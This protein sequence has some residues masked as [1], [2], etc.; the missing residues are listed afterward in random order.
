MSFN[1]SKASSRTCCPGNTLSLS[2]VVMVVVGQKRNG[3]QGRLCLLRLS[4]V[5]CPKGSAAILVLRW[6]NEYGGS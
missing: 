3:W 5:W 4:Y 2:V 6:K 1:K